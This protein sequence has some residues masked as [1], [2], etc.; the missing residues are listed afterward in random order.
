[1]KQRLWKEYSTNYIKVQSKVKPEEYYTLKWKELKYYLME[2]LSPV[3]IESIVIQN[4]ITWIKLYKK[5]GELIRFIEHRMIQ[6]LYS[7]YC[8][9]NTSEAN[10]EITNLT[11]DTLEQ[12]GWS[13]Y[14]FN[15]YIRSKYHKYIDRMSYNK[16]GIFMYKTHL[17]P[18]TKEQEVQLKMKLKYSIQAKM[19]TPTE[20]HAFCRKEQQKRDKETTIILETMVSEMREA[21]VAAHEANKVVEQPKTNNGKQEIEDDEL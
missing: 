6:V 9:Y 3:Y 4:H 2:K 14:Q 17:E 13:T 20:S 10:N 8:R 21:S 11:L 7:L 12:I 1:M 18:L 15:N 19:I 5:Y 16:Y